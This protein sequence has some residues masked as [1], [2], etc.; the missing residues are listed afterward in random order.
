MALRPQ[1][2]TELQDNARAQSLEIIRNRIDQFGVTEPII[3]PQG[4]NQIVVQLPGLQDPQRAIELIGQTA[5]LEFKLVEDQHGL[6]LDELIDK[7]VAQGKLKTGYTREEL[8]HVLADK[9]P[10]DSEVY[11]EKSIDRRPPNR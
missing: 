2:V 10:P 6:N 8:N 7:A 1:V 5:Q 9:L 3:V 11:I 4:E